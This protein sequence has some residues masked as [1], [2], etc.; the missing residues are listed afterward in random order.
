ME[1]ISE[2]A[3]DQVSAYFEAKLRDDAKIAAYLDSLAA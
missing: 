2:R 3:N 1:H